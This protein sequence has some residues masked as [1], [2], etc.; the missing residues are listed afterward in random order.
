MLLCLLAHPLP[1]CAPT[2]WG[3]DCRRGCE[4]SGEPH[5]PGGPGEGAE[6]TLAAAVL[7]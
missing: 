2:T 5:R 3:R 4:E 6:E 1:L 7:A